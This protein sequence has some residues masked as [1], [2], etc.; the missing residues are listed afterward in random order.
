MKKNTQKSAKAKIS[1]NQKAPKVQLK[2]GLKAG[3]KIE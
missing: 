2:T 1:K 3:A